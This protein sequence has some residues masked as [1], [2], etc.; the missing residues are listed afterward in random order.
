MRVIVILL[1]LLT[2]CTTKY[3]HSDPKANFEQD[4]YACEKDA[5]PVQDGWRQGRMVRQCMSA[6]GWHEKS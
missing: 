3:Y 2:G 6:K 1:L 4:N 5:A